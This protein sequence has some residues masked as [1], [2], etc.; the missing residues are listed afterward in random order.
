M[1]A[2]LAILRWL[3]IG[4][5]AVCCGD[6]AAQSC[7]A[8]PV[9]IDPN[10]VTSTFGKSRTLA[11]YSGVAH[12]HWGVDFQAR[13]PANTATGADLLA[14]DNG[15]VIGAGFWGAGYG[16]RVALK[17]D[18]GD[19]VIYSHLAKVEGRLKSGAAAGFKETDGGP[20]LGNTKVAVGEKVGVAGG[21]ADH[22]STNQRAVHLHL[23]YVT[24]YAGSKLRETND[25]TDTTRSRYMRN[26][27]PYMC[28]TIKHA[29]GAGPVTEGS[30][31]AAPVPAGGSAT[32][33]A[34]SPNS[35]DQIYEA[36]VSQPDVTDRERYGTPDA[37]PYD[38]Y[39]GMSESQIIE[40]EMLRRTL[41]TEW[42]EK[43]SSW[44]RR[45]L[46]VEIARMRGVKV[47]MDQ[48]IAEK[49]QRVEAML[50]AIGAAQT[51]RFMSP[52]LREAYL[53]A[54]A[55]GSLNKVK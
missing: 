34:N 24:N 19:I 12:I 54:Q 33:N 38:T 40:A 36:G 52:K 39:A 50:A 30:G 5:L 1:M 27:L 41:D 16:N 8:D 44:S 49:A 3:P 37:P 23:E 15:T 11:Q 7:L 29:A 46:L 31:G 53:R 18:N 4:I 45:G 35:D 48:R 47:W 20:G 32:G 13:N 43:L 42:E 25:G 51:N 10:M 26:V 17:R 2:C 21:T 9:K 6:A 14:V 28:H 22:M 55:Q